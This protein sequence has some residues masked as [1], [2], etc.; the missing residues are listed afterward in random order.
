MQAELFKLKG[1]AG[2][3]HSSN[4]LDR[5]KCRLKIRRI[6]LYDTVPKQQEPGIT[7]PG[8]PFQSYFQGFF[9]IEGFIL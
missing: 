1:N 2:T 3:N 9:I 8:G 7:G 4:K 5:N 6:G